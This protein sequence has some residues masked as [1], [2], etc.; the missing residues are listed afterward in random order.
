MT[1]ALATDHHKT[2]VTTKNGE[3]DDLIVCCC[4]LHISGV[5]NCSMQNIVHGQRND[6]KYREGKEEKKS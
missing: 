4:R 5:W 1:L 2:D 3:K 6:K